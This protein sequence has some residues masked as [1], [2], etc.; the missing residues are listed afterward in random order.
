[1]RRVCGKIETAGV[2]GSNCGVRGRNRGG[3]IV[4]GRFFNSVY[5]T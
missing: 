1:M 3:A 4:V 2:S 5:N